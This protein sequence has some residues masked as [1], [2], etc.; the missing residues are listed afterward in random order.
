VIQLL[1]VLSWR[2]RIINILVRITIGVLLIVSFWLGPQLSAGNG[3]DTGNFRLI[4]IALTGTSFASMLYTLG[5]GLL[6]RIQEDAFYPIRDLEIAR[7]DIRGESIVLVMQP[8]Q[9]DQA[10]VIG[11][12]ER[13]Y[14]LQH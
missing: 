6:Y 1:K 14:E 11:P 3:L 10:R 12:V 2:G 13:A 8:Q 5:R 7:A 9:V 4:A